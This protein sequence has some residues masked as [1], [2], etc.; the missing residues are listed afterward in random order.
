M[1]LN[2]LFLLFANLEDLYCLLCHLLL[3]FMSQDL[4]K[5]HT[6]LSDQVKLTT[7]SFVGVEVQNTLRLLSE[8]SIPIHEI[9]VPSLVLD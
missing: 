5:E 6:I 2:P 4:K 3:L 9:F 8:P 7:D 1:Y